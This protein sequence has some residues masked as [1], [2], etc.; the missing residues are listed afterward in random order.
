MNFYQRQSY[1]NRQ[2]YPQML[3]NRTSTRNHAKLCLACGEPVSCAQIFYCPDCC[4]CKA[5]SY[6]KSVGSPPPIKIQTKNAPTPLPLEI[7]DQ[8]T[9]DELDHALSLAENSS[10]KLGR[11]IKKLKRTNACV[12]KQLTSDVSNKKPR[13]QYSDTQDDLVFDYLNGT[14]SDLTDK[15]RLAQPCSLCA[16]DS[17][18]S[19]RDHY[20]EILGRVPTTIPSI[21]EW[22]SSKF[23][24]HGKSPSSPKV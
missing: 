21:L 3:A 15:Q 5:C 14:S 4:Y 2:R 16:T 23:Y 8:E 7:I 13:V 12:A 19:R 1:E 6:H 22:N 24:L 17:L 9:E 11:E 20:S 18:H 10:K